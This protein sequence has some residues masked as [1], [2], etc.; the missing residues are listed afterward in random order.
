VKIPAALLTVAFASF[1]VGFNANGA[2]T[3][4]GA[5]ASGKSSF[6]AG[7]PA[8]P[9]CASANSHVAWRECAVLE[10]D[11]ADAAL[12]QQF[13]TTLNRLRQVTEEDFA[14]AKAQGFGDE[15]YRRH[16]TTYVQSLERSQQA[17]MTYRREYCHADSFPGRN[18]NSN[19]ENF[20]GCEL[21]LIKA[22]IEQL[23]TLTKELQS[24]G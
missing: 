22:R 19:L 6:A 7:G 17:W 9:D 1:L 13:Q 18:G 3:A 4:P 20:I 16:L 15:E 11:R 2:E 10:R 12:K 24:D 23:Q 21:P 5:A 14:I 8:A